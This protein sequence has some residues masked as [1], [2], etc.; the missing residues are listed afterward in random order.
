MT[1]MGLLA[2]QLSEVF[3]WGLIVALVLTA[4]N[5]REVTGTWVPLAAGVVF[6]AVLIPTVM[7]PAAAPVMVQVG[8]GLVANAVILAAV[9]AGFALWGRV[10]GR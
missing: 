1:V 9:M 3:R 2:F 10:A 8:V 7:T 4:R 5:T 6:V